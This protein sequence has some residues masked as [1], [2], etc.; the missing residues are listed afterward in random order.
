[1][2]KSPERMEDERMCGSSWS[3]VCK[4]ALGGAGLL[5]G[6]LAVPA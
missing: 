6:Q 4:G 3:L 5:A 2:F 1:M